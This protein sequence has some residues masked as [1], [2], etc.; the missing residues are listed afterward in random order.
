MELTLGLYRSFREENAKKKGDIGEDYD[1]GV[2]K[3]DNHKDGDH[4]S[5]LGKLPNHPT[6]SDESKYSSK[7]YRGGTWSVNDK[8]QDVFTLS[9]DMMKSGAGK[10]ISKY[11]EEFEPDAIV[12]YPPYKTPE[13]YYKKGIKK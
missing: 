12:Q 6:F 1:Y 3:L 2:M 10:N 8:G 13:D 11:F 5:D 4:Y 9:E 7:K